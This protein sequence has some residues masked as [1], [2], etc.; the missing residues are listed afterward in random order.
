MG[1]LPF[2]RFLKLVL[3][4]RPLAERGGMRCAFPPYV[5]VVLVR[6][7]ITRG[8]PARARS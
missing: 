7:G 4:G 1:A 5:A 3:I 2:F 8:A 6:I